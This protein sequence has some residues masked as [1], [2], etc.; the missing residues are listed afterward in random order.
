MLSINS[1]NLAE[2]FKITHKVC[3]QVTKDFLTCW[4]NHEPHDY[5]AASMPMEAFMITDKVKV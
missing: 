4:T 5:K 1:K 3:S 2:V